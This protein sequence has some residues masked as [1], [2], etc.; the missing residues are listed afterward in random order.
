VRSASLRERYPHSR[1]FLKFDED[2]TPLPG[3]PERIRVWVSAFSR[4]LREEDFA[5][6]PYL[7]YRNAVEKG[8]LSDFLEREREFKA[9]FRELSADG[10]L[11]DGEKGMQLRMPDDRGLDAIFTEVVRERRAPWAFHFLRYDVLMCTGWDLT[12]RLFLTGPEK[13]EP[14]RRMVERNR[15]HL[16]TA[17]EHDAASG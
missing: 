14:L 2:G 17:S 1:H 16:L 5:N 3:Q 12:H 7:F 13:V 11:I 8:L 15:L 10:V 6:A 4:W 9:L